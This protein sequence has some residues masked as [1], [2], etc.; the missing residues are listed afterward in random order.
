MENKKNRT[1]AILLAFFLGGLGIQWFYLNKP[2]NGIIS[3]L[4]CWTFIPAL[5]ALFQIVMWLMMN[6]A[7]F[8]ETYG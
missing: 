1:V 5:V 2:L 6:D 8:A 3:F 7:K 4:F